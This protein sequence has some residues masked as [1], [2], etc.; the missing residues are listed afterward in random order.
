M[1]TEEKIKIEYQE[2]NFQTITDYFVAGYPKGRVQNYEVFFDQHK[3][4]V[5]LKLYLKET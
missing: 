5:I 2:I 4:K 3:Q 1:K